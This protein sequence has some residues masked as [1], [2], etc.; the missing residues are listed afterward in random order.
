MDQFASYFGCMDG[1]NIALQWTFRDKTLMY[2]MA[3]DFPIF[4]TC[5]K[6]SRCGYD[7]LSTDVVVAWTGWL[8][9]GDD[10]RRRSIAPVSQSGCYS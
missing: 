8:T 2:L 5:F 9:M 1:W 3:N 10:P 4:A 6:W 7:P